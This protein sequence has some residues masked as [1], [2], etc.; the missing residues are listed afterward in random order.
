MRIDSS[1]NLLV[2]KT[3]VDSGVVGVEAKANGTLVATVNGDTVSLL[4]RKTSDG[5]ILRLQKDGSTVGSIGT[6]SGV[7]YFYGASGFRLG[8]AIQPVTSAG[9]LSDNTTDIGQSN[10]RFKD[11]Y[12]SGGVYLGGTVAANKLDDYELGYFSPTI[13][14][15]SSNPT[16][17]YTTTST[18]NS[19]GTGIRGRYVVIGTKVF[20][21]VDIRFS[22][23]TGGGGTYRISNL[24]FAATSGYSAGVVSEHTSGF[25]YSSYSTLNFE[26]QSG[27][28]IA[29]L[30][31]S[32]SGLTSTVL[33]SIS[34]HSG[35]IIGSFSYTIA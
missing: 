29:N 14:R 26:V 21:E 17:T 23:I 3:G 33:S 32:G 15:S 7:P 25:T 10:A 27:G 34:D 30:I 28:S 35:Y 1:G 6:N 11:L 18:F 24:P 8:G 31:L 5:E 22:A 12:L 13:T 20:C 9:A 16:V 19:Y 4:N 2:G